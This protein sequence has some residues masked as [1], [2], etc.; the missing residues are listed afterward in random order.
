M[1]SSPSSCVFNR[2]V[3]SAVSHCLLPHTF[4]FCSLSSRLQLVKAQLIGCAILF[5]TPPDSCIFWQTLPS[6][7]AF[8]WMHWSHV[9]HV[10]KNK[11]YCSITPEPK[12]A[13][14]FCCRWL[15]IVLVFLYFLFNT[16]ILSFME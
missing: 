14:M 6:P 10:T 4:W 5:W 11:I 8:S 1:P 3:N 16:L 2:F 7:A 9:L 12:R 15:L 13:S